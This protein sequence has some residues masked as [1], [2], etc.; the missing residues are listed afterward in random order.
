[1]FGKF[2]WKE[3]GKERKKEG[4]K[5]KQKIFFL[6]KFMRCILFNCIFWEQ[7]MFLLVE[8]GIDIERDKQMIDRQR[9]KIGNQL[10]FVE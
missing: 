1:M 7:K 4:V 3:G 2:L 8:F 10:M 6:I 9:D 5:D